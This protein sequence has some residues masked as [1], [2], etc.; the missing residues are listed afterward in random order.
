MTV[1]AEGRL[2]QSGRGSLTE[3][4]GATEWSLLSATALI[5][6]SSFLLIEVALRAFQPGVVAL[7]RVVLGAA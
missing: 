4:F 3:A 5:W 7:G 1:E 6:G 2:L